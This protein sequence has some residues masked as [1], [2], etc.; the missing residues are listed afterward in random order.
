LLA[1]CELNSFILNACSNDLTNADVAVWTNKRVDESLQPV[2]W[3]N[4]KLKVQTD[5]A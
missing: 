5:W 1:L 3:I 4:Q 2:D